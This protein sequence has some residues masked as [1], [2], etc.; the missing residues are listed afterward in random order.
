[1]KAVSALTAA[2]RLVQLDSCGQSVEEACL[3]EVGL[4]MMIFMS[5]LAC[6][7][8]VG[9]NMEMI[10]MMNKIIIMGLNIAV[11]SLLRRPP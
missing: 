5:I 2:F 11:A 9:M 8:E 3:R 6:L 1:M 7:R 10:M 4:M